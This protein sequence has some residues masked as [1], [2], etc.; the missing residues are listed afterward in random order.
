MASYVTIRRK[1]FMV[2][3]RTAIDCLIHVHEQMFCQKVVIFRG[4]YICTLFPIL[5]LPLSE[6]DTK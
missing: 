4:A 3:R 1:T 5:D 2:R 6:F